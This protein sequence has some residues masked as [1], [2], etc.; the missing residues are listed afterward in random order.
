MKKTIK[1]TLALSALILF[2]FSVNAAVCPSFGGARGN[3]WDAL[4]NVPPFHEV[5]SNDDAGGA[6]SGAFMD[7]DP[8][9]NDNGGRA[10]PGAPMNNEMSGNDNGGHAGAQIPAVSAGT[11]DCASRDSL[12]L[13]SALL[14]LLCVYAALRVARRHGKSFLHIRHKLAYAKLIESMRKVVTKF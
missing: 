14:A 4:F 12:P 6:G 5:A 10:G 1:P 3:E 7:N 2:L 13:L 8:G 9:G 11:K